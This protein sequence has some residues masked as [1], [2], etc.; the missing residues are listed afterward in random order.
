MNYGKHFSLFAYLCT[1][2]FFIKVERFTVVFLLH[3]VISVYDVN[4]ILLI[5][6]ECQVLER[7]WLSK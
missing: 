1:L 3:G 7:H 5:H 6:S 2:A 4:I